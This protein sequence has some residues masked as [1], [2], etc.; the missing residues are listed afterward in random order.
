MIIAL[1]FLGSNGQEPEPVKEPIANP[2]EIETR[3]DVTI[4]D[5]INDKL[6]KLENC[7]VRVM[8]KLHIINDI[9][10]YTKTFLEGDRYEIIIS[11]RKK[12]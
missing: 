12:I 11:I 1:C 6:I 10:D 5:G 4:I 7:K 2:A 8:G 9:F 3:L